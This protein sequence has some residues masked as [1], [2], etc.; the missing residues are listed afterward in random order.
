M[1]PYHFVESQKIIPT[2]LSPKNISEFSSYSLISQ[3][4]A[5]TPNSLKHI[6]GFT[7]I[8]EITGQLET[9]YSP[10][11]LDQTPIPTKVEPRFIGTPIQ[12]DLPD[13]PKYIPGVE[14]IPTGA[15]YGVQA[16]TV[17]GDAT[18]K[19]TVVVGKNGINYY[20]GPLITSGANIYLVWYGD[21]SQ[22]TATTIVPDFVKALNGS[23]YINITST[24]SDSK[25]NRPSTIVN[26][27]NS[28]SVGYTKGKDKKG[29]PNGLGSLDIAGVVNGVLKSGT[30]PK[31]PNGV[32]VVLTSA[33]V[34]GTDGFCN[35]FCAYHNSYSSSPSLSFRY[36]FV[37]NPDRCPAACGVVK[38]VGNDTPNG[39]SGADG[40]AN[41]IS[42]EI[43]EFITDPNY[44]GWHTS[45]GSEVGDLC[46]W[47]F[48][49]PYKT[50]SGASANIKLGSKDYMIQEEW[51]NVDGGKCVMGYN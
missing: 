27:I 2:E 24:Y 32:Y 18:T 44:D 19:N 42:H 20:G 25:G 6:S 47:S 40:I 15:G 35:R 51:I 10:K 1:I 7:P 37:G 43:E 38:H 29:I 48:G 23:A 33:D 5:T 21:W 50:K 34:P 41:L 49:S 45:N 31:D 11:S 4:L 22:N 8:R 16:T 13:I 12:Q 36:I 39:N 9:K 46:S 3:P 14:Y 30:L 26:Y 17:E 28:T